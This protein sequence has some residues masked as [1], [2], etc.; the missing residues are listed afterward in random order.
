MLNQYGASREEMMGYSLQDFFKHDINKGYEVVMDLLDN[1]KQQ[2]IIKEQK[3]DG[4]TFW[5]EGDYVCLYNNDGDIRGL[6]GFQKDISDRIE[7]EEDLR[8]ITEDLIGSNN[9]LQQFAYLTSHDLRAPVVNLNSLLNFY[10]KDNPQ[11]KDNPIIIKKIEESVLR[12]QNTLNDLVN[13]VALKK[14]E[15]ESEKSVYFSKVTN[16][17]KTSIQTLLSQVEHTVSVE[18]NVKTIK[19]PKTHLHSIVQNLLTNAIKYRSTK[20]ALEIGIKT[21]NHDDYVCLEIRDNGLGIDMNKYGDKLF[22]IYQRFHNVANSK[23]LGLYIVKTQVEMMGGYIDVKSKV[24]QGTTFK[25]YLLK[26]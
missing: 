17:V 10:N 6:F 8:K 25:I 23:G 3:L 24:N 15:T 14:Q 2:K 26:K 4:T 13:I 19:Y 21:Y 22:G 1:G 9:E 16:D 12:L 20:R 18:F 7:T 5:I 11:D